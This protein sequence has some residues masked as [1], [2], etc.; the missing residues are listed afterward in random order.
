MSFAS[1]NSIG[2][3]TALAN[4]DMPGWPDCF[5]CGFQR[6]N[7]ASFASLQISGLLNQTELLTALAAGTGLTGMAVLI[8]VF[9]EETS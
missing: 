6:V 8:A 3:L 1:L 4:S 7:I 5:D 2:L 9:R